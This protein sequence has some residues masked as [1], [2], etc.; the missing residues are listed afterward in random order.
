MMGRPP[1]SPLFPSPT[2]S[3]SGPRR[4][5]R[6]GTCSK[7]AGGR[8]EPPVSGKCVFQGGS[9][10]S[11]NLAASR[12]A[13][14]HMAATYGQPVDKPVGEL[15]LDEVRWTAGHVAW[16]REQVQALEVGALVWGDAERVT[17]EFADAGKPGSD[18]VL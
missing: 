12:Q 14:A 4:A 15:V 9:S 8:I 1:I 16:L 3:G 7:P 5:N 18:A 17:R 6:D 10:P 2:L 11:H 13:A